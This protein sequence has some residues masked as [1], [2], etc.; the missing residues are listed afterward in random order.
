M[1]PITY[2]LFKPSPH[3][4]NAKSRKQQS[5]NLG[6]HRRPASSYQ[7][8]K[9]RREPEDGPGKE[10]V[11]REGEGGAQ[12]AVLAGK[13]HAGG[14]YRG[15][16]NQGN[17]YGYG[18]NIFGLDHPA[19]FFVAQQIAHGEGEEQNTAGDHEVGESYAEKIENLVACPNK[20]DARYEGGEDGYDENPAE[21]LR[22]DIG[23]EVH[24]ERHDAEGVD[25]YEEWDEAEDEVGHCSAMIHIDAR[26]FHDRHFHG[27]AGS[28]TDYDIAAAD[29]HNLV[30]RVGTF[31]CTKG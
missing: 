11:H 15:A 30:D 4:H 29:P 12:K 14:E 1:W 6:Y 10:D 21:F 13:E 9:K 16:H 2:V 25:G 17:A 23:S 24:E 27:S 31:E 18:R 7:S 20:Q 26:E 22:F 28:R 5:C 3:H 8:H 19:A